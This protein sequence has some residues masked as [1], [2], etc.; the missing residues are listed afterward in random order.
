MSCLSARV[1]RISSLPLMLPLLF[2]QVGCSQ[3]RGGS[4]PPG[5]VTI[6]FTIPLALPY[7]GELTIDGEP[8]EFLCET[9]GY[10]THSTEAPV[11]IECSESNLIVWERTVLPQTL[12]LAMT[13]DA[14]PSRATGGCLI[15]DYVAYPSIDDPCSTLFSIHTLDTS[16]PPP[17]SCGS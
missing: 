10:A 1:A 4:P 8:W 3:C 5:Y 2:L 16:L 9:A 13:P 11:F 6:E 7:E 17:A 12:G 14:D 15:M